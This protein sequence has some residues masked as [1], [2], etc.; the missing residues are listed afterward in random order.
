MG[1]ADGIVFHARRPMSYP[2]VNTLRSGIIWLALVSTPSLGIA[3]TLSNGLGGGDWSDSDT[4]VGG[5]VPSSSFA[6]QETDTVTA[7]PGVNYSRDD[8]N[9]E[10]YGTL[11][12]NGGDITMGRLNYN[13]ESFGTI[14]LNDGNVSVSRVAQTKESRFIVNISD[15]TFEVRDNIAVSDGITFN[16]S[17][18][19]LRLGGSSI[20][21]YSETG[22]VVN[23]TGG[24][25][26]FM[27]GNSGIGALAD[28]RWNGGTVYLNN[29]TMSAG[30][31]VGVINAWT[32]NAIN[33][34]GLSSKK[35]KQT[36]TMETEVVATQGVISFNIY[37]ATQND[38][39]LFV[40]NSFNLGENVSIQIS[41][42]GLEGSIQDYIGATY[43]LFS[44]NNGAYE[45]IATAVE[46]STLNIG[47]I[48]YENIRWDTSNLAVNGTI[49]LVPEPSTYAL[50]A[51]L[52]VMGIAA[53]RRRK[54]A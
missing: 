40:G 19:Q 34:L 53:T 9:S 50:A 8:R 18:G 33:V 27:N 43:Q 38:N 23:M 32:A 3:Q 29:S 52:L 28:G 35:T 51:G 24:S 44:A 12:V 25:I 36:L 2:Y 39:D 11:T 13:K 17:G 22:A 30:T 16:V 49:S 7:G 48:V 31:S 46:D 47:G 1:C 54:I 15:G 10:I 4:W 41:G 20:N 5:N 37:S 45:N 21:Q 6:I 14:N 42:V 26:T